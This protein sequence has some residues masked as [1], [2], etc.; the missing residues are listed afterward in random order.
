MFVWDDIQ[1]LFSSVAPDYILISLDLIQSVSQCLEYIVPHGMAIRIVYAF[2]MIGIDKEHA[3]V[4]FVR[5][6][7][8][9]LLMQQFH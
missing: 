8:S 7:F 4:L 2:E 6:V 9:E 1:E 5:I 3:D